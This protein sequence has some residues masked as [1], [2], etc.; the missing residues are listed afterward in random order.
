M[1]KHDCLAVS[2]IVVHQDCCISQTVMK[3]IYSTRIRLKMFILSSLIRIGIRFDCHTG[4]WHP[5]V[6]QCHFLQYTANSKISFW[7]LSCTCCVYIFSQNTVRQ[8]QFS[9]Q[10]RG[11]WNTRTA[12][13]RALRMPNNKWLLHDFKIWKK[14]QSLKL[15]RMKNIFGIMNPQQLNHV[16][17]R[18]VK[19]SQ[20]GFK[21]SLLTV[22]TDDRPDIEE[23]TESANNQYSINTQSIL[24]AQWRFLSSETCFPQ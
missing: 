5:V 20:W 21:L 24:K 4:H 9:S 13:N 17:L 11:V 8:P 12:T 22:A 15:R 16:L 1:C 7:W 18:S 19:V 3:F 2:L 23:S 6:P 10:R 14:I